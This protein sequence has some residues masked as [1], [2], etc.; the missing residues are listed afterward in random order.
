MMVLVVT[1]RGEAKRKPNWI[2][3]MIIIA[4]IINALNGTMEAL[5]KVLPVV[6]YAVFTI[7]HR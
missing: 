2:M 7:T 1:G 3:N 6:V 4:I 5:G